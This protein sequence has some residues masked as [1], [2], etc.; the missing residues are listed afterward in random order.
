MNKNG[1][2]LN[3]IIPLISILSIIVLW[4]ILAIVVNNQALLPSL[5]TTLKEFFSLFIK[6]EFYHAFFNTLLRSL[7]SFIFSFSLALALAVLTYKSKKAQ[8]YFAPIISIIRVLPTIAV[9]LPLLVWT[10]NSFVTPIIVTFLV[11]FPTLYLNLKN[12][13]SSIDKDQIEMCK[14]FNVGKKEI[15][16]KVIFPQILPPVILSMG[17]GLSL[18]VKLMVAAEVL[19]YTVSAIGDLLRLAKLYEQMSTMMALVLVTVI[20]GLLIEWLFSFISKK[21]GKWQ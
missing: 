5:T 8:R 15:Y 6:A 13:L 17:A 18:N 9:V 3:L 14:V 12:A 4:V 11:V 1:K 21:V 19:A 20:L 2:I 10:K 16:T 7:L